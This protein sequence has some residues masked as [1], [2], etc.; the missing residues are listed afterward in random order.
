MREHTERGILPGC[1]AAWLGCIQAAR[2]LCELLCIPFAVFFA[3]FC[4]FL[5][6]LILSLLAIFGERAIEVAR[7]RRDRRDPFFKD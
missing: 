1:F 5:L 6:G 2:F 3:L 4:G 7:P